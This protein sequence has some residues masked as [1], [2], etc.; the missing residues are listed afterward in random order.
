MN[1][2][3]ITVS[4]IA[5]VSMIITGVVILKPVNVK[6]ELPNVGAL[7][8]PD[9]PYNWLTVGGVGYEFG[10]MTIRTS[11]TTV[12]S[13]QSPAATS[14]LIFASVAVTTG[15]STDLQYEMA[16]SL[17]NNTATT[18]SLGILNLDASAPGTM[19]ASTSPVVGKDTTII[20]GPSE[21]LVVKYGSLTK[22]VGASSVSNGLVGTCKAVWLKN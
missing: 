3:L 15:T 10:S 9:I 11:S 5:I 12:C 4:A 18:T 13:F 20:F 8:G 16:K 22:G 1:K 6:V 14:T 17:V 2:T 7:A 21:W 19:V